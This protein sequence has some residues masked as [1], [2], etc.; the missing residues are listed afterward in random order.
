M[1]LVYYKPNKMDQLKFIYMLAFKIETY[2]CIKP[3][4]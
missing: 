4:S 1:T 2:K 3:A